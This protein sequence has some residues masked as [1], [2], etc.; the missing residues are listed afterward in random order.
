MCVCESADGSKKGPF[1]GDI[2]GICVPQHGAVS[3]VTF[4][5]CPANSVALPF[6]T[7]RHTLF[8]FF[9]FTL[10]DPEIEQRKQSTH[11]C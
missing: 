4:H 7:L 5:L 3:Q 9:F 11:R 2:G 1:A 8:S 10:L 6:D